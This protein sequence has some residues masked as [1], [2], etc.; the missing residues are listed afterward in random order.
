VRS[1]LA[2]DSEIMCFLYIP[3]AGALF[4]DPQDRFLVGP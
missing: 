3:G 2:R 4:L 1:P